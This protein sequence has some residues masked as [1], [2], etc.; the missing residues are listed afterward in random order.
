[1]HRARAIATLLISAS[2]GLA[3]ALSGA[4]AQGDGGGKGKGKAQEQVQ[5]LPG[6]T[7]IATGKDDASL[8]AFDQAGNANWRI[9]E[10]TLAADQGAGFLVTKQSYADFQLH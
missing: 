5:T 1:M 6:M 9:A 8:G 7:M 2:L 4:V 3:G 10:Q